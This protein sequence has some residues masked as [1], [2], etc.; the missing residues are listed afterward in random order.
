MAPRHGFEPREPYKISNARD[1]LILQSLLSRQKPQKQVGG[2][3]SVQNI[4]EQPS[5]GYEIRDTQAV[6]PALLGSTRPTHNRATRDCLEFV[7]K[8]VNDCDRTV[9]RNDEIRT[10]GS[11]CFARAARYPLD[12][13][14]IAHFLRVGY[15]GS[16]STLFAGSGSGE[17]RRRATGDRLS[18]LFCMRLY[19]V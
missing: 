15:P 12:P 5:N 17:Q 6:K 7:E 18:V 4:L 9:A 1:L 10:G 16:I 14:A 2:T 11:G 19:A 3:K 13:T 8:K